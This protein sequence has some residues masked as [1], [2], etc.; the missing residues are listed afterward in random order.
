MA[1]VRL[2]P[3]WL[4]LI[5]GSLSSLLVWSAGCELGQDRND[6]SPALA[7]GPTLADPG[8][9]EN[10]ASEPP[11][12]ATEVSPVFQHGRGRAPMGAEAIPTYFLPE[13]DGVTAVRDGLVQL[14]VPSGRS[15]PVIER[16]PVPVM[17]HDDLMEL[18]PSYHL[19]GAGTDQAA[20]DAL[21]DDLQ[22]ELHEALIRGEPRLKPPASPAEEIAAQLLPQ[23]QPAPDVG[24]PWRPGV[25]EAEYPGGTWP[26]VR[27]D[28]E[29]DGADSVGQVTFEFV[30]QQDWIDW[31]PEAVEETDQEWELALYDTALSLRTALI[32]RRPG[33]VYAVFY[34]PCVLLAPEEDGDGEDAASQAARRRA[35]ELLRAQVEEFAA[36][37]DSLSSRVE[38][39]PET[40]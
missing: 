1:R 30:S 36:W 38:S 22:I 6:T 27:L 33:G 17:T 28:L 29:L 11:G 4:C 26:S 7:E 8:G 3:L 18:V 35:M 13:A 2:N 10:G 32:A 21:I 19:V 12:P 31:K 39:G 5:L 25:S 9:T 16:L 20:V 37:Y 23:G 15:M 24:A 34:D 14:G 40:P